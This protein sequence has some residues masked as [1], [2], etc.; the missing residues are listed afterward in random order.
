MLEYSPQ[1]ANIVPQT[2]RYSFSLSIALRNDSS[3]SCRDFPY[4]FSA[5][6]IAPQHI[7][8]SLSGLHLRKPLVKKTHL[9]HPSP[10]KGL[11][12]R[13]CYRSYVMKP[14]LP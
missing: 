5:H 14:L 13:F 7:P 4:F 8:E 6:R 12:L 2:L 10:Q 3:L 1:L 11:Y 9:K